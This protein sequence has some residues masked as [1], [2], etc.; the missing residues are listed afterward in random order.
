MINL[1]SDNLQKIEKFIL[2]YSGIVISRIPAKGIQEKI[3][4]HIAL[5]G[6]NSVEDYIFLLKSPSGGLIRDELMSRITVAES[7]FFRNP[8]QFKYI[9]TELF[10]EFVE[11]RRALDLNEIKIWSAGCAGGE[12]PFS[13]AY[14]V[15]W[16]LRAK[17]DAKFYI[18]A[19][20]INS[21]NL[22]KARQGLF[23][24]RSF[25][26]QSW[27]FQKEY[28]LPLTEENSDGYRIRRE[29]REI[30]NFK[31]LNLKDIDSLKTQAGSDI[32]L[33][34]NVL[35]Y[36]EERFRIELAAMFHKLLNPGGMLFLGE[37]ESLS[38]F[39]ELF[40]LKHCLGAYGYRK[41]RQ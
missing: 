36:F 12:E 16:F 8:S 9:S 32:I 34:R 11:N 26:K 13:V 2:D 19:S 10:S 38:S 20:D 28:K 18:T 37:T 40:E 33:C 24:P 4:Q 7:F 41:I 14:I 5:L 3:G 6:L 30:V 29:I 23:K 35:I 22:E 1:T 25:R 17:P 31:F 15:K 27:E 39:N 21:R